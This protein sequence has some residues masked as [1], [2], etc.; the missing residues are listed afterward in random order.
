M[1]TDTEFTGLGSR[2]NNSLTINQ[3]HVLDGFE[4]GKPAL[5]CT[6]GDCSR[7]NSLEPCASVLSYLCPRFLYLLDK[8]VTASNDSLI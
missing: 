1:I 4:L 3:I 5:R 2:P 6:D 7:S 8:A